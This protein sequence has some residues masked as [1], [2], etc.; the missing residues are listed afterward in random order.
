[1]NKLEIIASCEAFVKE[2]MKDYE[3]G[4][5]W[6]HTDRVRRLALRINE[7]EGGDP[8][9]VEL[10]A[11][12]HDVG[13]F[14]FFKGDE[15]EAETFIREKLL[16]FGADQET[17]ERVV[18]STQRVSFKG[19]GVKETMESPE[20]KIVQ[21]A[22]RLDAMGAIGAARCFSYGAVNHRPLYDPDKPPTTHETFEEYKKYKS[23]SLNHFYEKLLLLKDRMNT[24]TGK[25]LAE[26]RHKFL[27]TYVEQFLAEWNGE[28]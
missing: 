16:S 9:F 23:T 7:K 24:E 3:P 13:D 4:H 15:K 19:S 26:G 10:I 14:K 6:Q 22:D 8:F 28:R 20:G 21:D 27:E 18:D 17:A 2:R 25:E 5:D 12:L 11:L 1:M